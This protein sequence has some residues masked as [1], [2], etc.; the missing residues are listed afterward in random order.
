MRVRKPPSPMWRAFLKDHAKEI[1]S[2]DFLVVPTVRFKTLY[3]LLFLSTERRHI[4]HF[5]V[6]E[7]PTAA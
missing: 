7:H 3:V 6:T 5:A 1:V 4:V 2:I